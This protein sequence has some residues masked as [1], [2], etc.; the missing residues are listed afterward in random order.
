MKQRVAHTYCA[1]NELTDGLSLKPGL[2]ILFFQDTMRP[3][4]R[5]KR[6]HLITEYKFIVMVFPR[7][8]WYISAAKNYA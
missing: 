2:S 5:H 1:P 8:G 4:K 3:K 7:K 6:A